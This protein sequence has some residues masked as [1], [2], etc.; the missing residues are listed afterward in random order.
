[1]HRQISSDGAIVAS[2]EQSLDRLYG[3]AEWRTVLIGQKTVPTLFGDVDLTE[4]QSSADEATRFMI[5]RMKTIFD[6][7]V[8]DS[9]LPLGRSGAHWYSLI[10]ACGN[11][12]VG[13]L[14]IAVRIA[15]SAIKKRRR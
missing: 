10:F 13:A 14:E 4:K 2:S 8:L 11:T 15:K 5:E 6:G 9:W 3:T 12:L 1:M 7:R